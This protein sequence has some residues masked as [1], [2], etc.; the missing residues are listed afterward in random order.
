M[1]FVFRREKGLSGGACDPT[2]Q[3]NEGE[4]AEAD[5]SLGEAVVRKGRVVRRKGTGW[6]G[7]S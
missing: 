7:R 2:L 5:H 6:S 4:A 1:R 3:A